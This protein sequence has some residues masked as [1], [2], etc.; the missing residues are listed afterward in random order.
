MSI[1]DKQIQIINN[2]KS[3]LGNLKLSNIDSS[4]SSFCYFTSW[5]ETPGYARLKL[6]ADGWSFVL[7]FCNILLKN[8][9]AIASH[10]KYVEFSNQNSST[11]YDMIVITW[12]YKKNFQSDGSFQDRYFNENSYNCVKSMKMT[13]KMP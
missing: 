7:K 8:I 5:A 13:T 6:Q 4:L 3:F 9:L 12:A 11:N 1:G 2:A 10:A